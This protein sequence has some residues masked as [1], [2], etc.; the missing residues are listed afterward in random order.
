M[1]SKEPAELTNEDLVREAKRL[2][3]LKI[4]DAV[5]IGV[6]LGIAIYSTVRSGAG[7]LSFLPLVYLPIARKN[8]IRLGKVEA[9]LQERGMT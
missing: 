3:P 7:L 5:L 9:L 2:R 6:L 1:A 8:R 4:M